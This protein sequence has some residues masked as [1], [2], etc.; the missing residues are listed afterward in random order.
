[1]RSLSAAEFITKPFDDRAVIAKFAVPLGTYAEV[2]M[3]R[4]PT[5]GIAFGERSPDI[6]QGHGVHRILTL[7]SRFVNEIVV[8]PL[9]KYL[10]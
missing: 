1:M 5:F 9:L 8:P 4:P 3:Q 6:I 7:L 10:A 2:S